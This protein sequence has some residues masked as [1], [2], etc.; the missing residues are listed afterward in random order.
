MPGYKGHLVGGAIAF[1]CMILVFGL[2]QKPTFFVAVQ[3]FF[4]TLFGALFPDIDTKSRGQG[5]FYRALLVFLGILL[6]KGQQQLCIVFS[7]LALSPLLV[8]HRG[9]FHKP[10]FL[11]LI[12]AL[13][14]WLCL[15]AGLIAVPLAVGCAFFFIIGALSHIILDKSF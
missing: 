15:Q 9:L 5:I 7:L 12:P 10:W 6:F 3:Y 8:R 14:A 1:S 4:C 13:I 2:W 11:I